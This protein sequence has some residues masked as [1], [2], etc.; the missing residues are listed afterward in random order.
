M[1]QYYPARFY[2]C[3]QV[4]AV[5]HT[6]R[7]SRSVGLK[8]YKLAFGVDRKFWFFTFIAPPIIYVNFHVDRIWLIGGFE[9][10]VDASRVLRECVQ[11]GVCI[12]IPELF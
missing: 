4:P 8:S 11:G 2:T 10:D 6:C 12:A 3:S 1:Y 9:D 7:E 5:I